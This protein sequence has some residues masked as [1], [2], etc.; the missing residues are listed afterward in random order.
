MRLGEHSLSHLDWTEQIR[1]SGFSATHP[2][3]QGALQSHDSDLRLLRL[4]TPVLLTRSVQPLALPTT[5]AAAGTKCH[6]SGW[7]TTNQPWSKE[8]G[9]RARDKQKSGAS[10][11]RSGVMPSQRKDG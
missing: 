6:I 10:G 2:N 3:Y 4:R 1:R 7:G 5:C 9:V 8:P 11:E